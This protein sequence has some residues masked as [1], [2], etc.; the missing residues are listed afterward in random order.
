LTS[1]LEL[2][3]KNGTI[4][5]GTLAVD[6]TQATVQAFHLNL[7]WIMFITEH[8]DSYNILSQLAILTEFVGIA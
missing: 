3:L 8:S 1:L 7:F 2:L 6:S 5:D 4:V